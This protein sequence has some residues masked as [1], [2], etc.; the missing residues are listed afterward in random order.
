MNKTY[1]NK[2]II[3]SL[4]LPGL[5]IFIFAT[6]APILLSI[7]YGT[8]EF[9]GI[10]SP[11][12][13]GLTN[14]KN[15]LFNDPT[16]YRAL[17]NSVLLG[18]GFI[19]VQHPLSF[20]FAI[21]LDKLGG[22]REKF[23][24]TAYF[25]PCVISVVVT[26][27]MWV[28]IFNYDFGLLNKVLD[29]LGLGFIKQEWLGDPNI[30]IWSIL[31]ICIWQGFGWAMLIYYSGLKGISEELYEAARIDGSTGFHMYTRITIPLMKPVI[32]VNLTLAMISALKQMETVYLTTNGGPGDRTM[33]LANYLYIKAFNSNEFGY[34]NA[35]SVLFVAICIFI[36]VMFNK[37]IRTD[38]MDY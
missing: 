8:T 17:L 30:A 18:F 13:T 10:G 35:I 36:T 5:L 23:F 25:I 32:K 1:S 31:V 11:V 2:L 28:N 37:A 12:F 16:F 20:V 26:C 33:F 21:F 29:F 19:I 27:S 7:Y 3:F 14:F 38:N 6:L 4:V 24:R 9:S 15:V 34:G 22:R